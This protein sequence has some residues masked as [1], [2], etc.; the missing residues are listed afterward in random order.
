[1]LK[2]R[3]LKLSFLLLICCLPTALFAFDIKGVVLDKQTREPL[4]GA[5]VQL[6]P[7]N[8]AGVTNLNGE[9]KI[10]TPKKG[11][12]QVEVK[13]LGFQTFHKE[14]TISNAEV[15]LLIELSTDDQL[16]DEVVV[17][18]RQVSYSD[19]GIISAQKNSLV[20]QSGVS[21][22]Q[23]KRTQDSDAS[24]VIKRIPGISIIDDKFVMVRGLSQRYNNVWI[25]QGAVP[26]SEADSRAFSFDIIPSSQI[27]NMVIVK[28]AAP[29]YPAD[30]TGGF[31]QLN[32][33]SIPESNNLSISLGGNVNT[34]T[35]F[36]NFSATKS[37]PTD[38]LGFDSSLRPLNNGINTSMNTFSQDQKAIDIL[39]NGL[40]NDWALRNKTPISDLKLNIAYNRVWKWN[41]GKELGMLASAN[42][43]NSYKT[44]SDMENSLFGSYDRINNHPVYLRKSTDNQYAHDAKLGALFNMAYRFNNEH[45]LEFKNSFNQLGKSRYTYREGFDAQSNKE[46]SMEYYYSAR[47]I[48]NTQLT[49]KHTLND[50]D[51]DWTLGY[52][53]SNRNLPDRRRILLNDELI[54]D[55]IGLTSGTDISREF[56]YLN[57]HIGSLNL[58]Y[59]HPINLGNLKTLIKAGAYGEYRTRS[60]NTRLFYYNWNYSQNSLPEGFR[61][62]PIVAELLQP[63]NYG[64]DKLYLQEQ[65]NKLNDYRGNNTHLA[66]YLAWNIPIDKLVIYAGL[67]YEYSK[68]ELISNTRAHEKS[69]R[70]SFYTY[71]DFFPSLNLSYNINDANQFRLAYGRTINRPEFRELSPSVYYDF[72]LA[73]NV[74][75]NHDL[76]AALIDNI[77]L[78]YEFYPSASELISLSLF[79]KR[80]SNPIEWTYTVNGGTNLTYSY[81]NAKAANNVG[82]E[83]ELKKNLD[84]IGLP[85]FSVNFNGAW[86]DS[87][88]SFASGS[89]EKSRAMQGQSPYLINTGLFYS[90]PDWQFNAGVLYNRIG[91]RIV[92][93]GRS[94]GTVGGDNSSDIPNSYEMPR[95]SLDFTLSKGFKNFEIKL[96]A[97]DILAEKVVF[98][99]IDESSSVKNKMEEITKSYRPGSNFG[100]SISYTLK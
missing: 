38:F 13:Y 70:S 3:L 99:Q 31:I 1:M 82:V 67:R 89:K 92:G 35:H 56:T 10:K 18:G 94:V 97:K 23:I 21:A 9:F 62:L 55:K 47:S 15:S 49:G 41:S 95:N 83:L 80:F 58:N 51:F 72:E 20:V 45:Q 86:I 87:R 39:G 66:G 79:Y 30:F 50:K 29:Q 96:Y 64:F 28:S 24:E 69:E 98:K 4:I 48:Y 8:I 43:S 40:N 65:V 93:V 73:S 19:V 60:Y 68:M 36:R 7:S 52:A 16:L 57:E 14:L 76:K 34:A 32:T 25:N 78:R 2:K 27:D 74:Q 84:F 100:L 37:G 42:Y 17:V 71:S 12:Y 33:K 81:T 46:K 85:N 63:N 77:D 59:A 54:Q 88:V 11:T 90:N 5:T 61:Y 26:S 53:Y 75:G 6:L 44:Y 91:K 22:Q